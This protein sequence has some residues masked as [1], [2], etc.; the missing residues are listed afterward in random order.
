M[1]TSNTQPRVLRHNLDA[2]ASIL[3]GVL[4]QNDVL[5]ELDRLE[6]DAFYDLRHRVV[7]AAMRNLQ[8]REKP[9]DPVTLVTE[10]E[11]NGKLEAIG[12][13]AFLGELALKVPTPTNVV[14][15]AETV[16][17][18]YATRRLALVCSDVLER[19]YDP[20]CEPEELLERAQAEVS[21]LATAQSK[22]DTLTP[23][24]VLARRRLKELDELAA[25]RAAGET[26]ALTGLP[27][28][29]RGLDQ[30]IGGWQFSV[31][32]MI[33]AR[34]A[35][36]KSSLALASADACTAAGYG[37][38]VF[39]L[40]DSWQ[41]YV[42]RCIARGSGVP[43]SAIRRGDLEAKR[44]GESP[45]GAVSHAVM[46]LMAR[47]NWHVDDRKD[48]SASEII[49]AVRKHKP[50]IGTRLVVVDYVQLV[51]RNHRLDENHAL[52]EIITAF[53]AAVEPDE[54]WLVLSQLNR[55]LEE[56][57]DKRP[58]MPDLRGSG[59]L[60]ERPKVIVG[61]YRG[62]EYG[63]EPRREIDYVCPRDCTTP[64][65][66]STCFVHKPT[67]EDWERQAQV[68]VLKHSNGD[69]GRVWATWNGPTTEIS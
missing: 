5:L 20:D 41:T 43:A 50:R 60:E 38:H 68:L 42:D 7:F 11:R 31:V 53:A 4:L 23:I 25:R 26:D 37:A 59:A 2:E 16:E 52:D 32:N 1:P 51:R 6:V 27:T 36:G 58:T 8:A 22:P 54:V 64:A 57:V 46:R 18:L 63:G 33:A 65:N 61:L 19:C 24:G 3:G 40:E 44:E 17:K 35:M 14:H 34:P 29:V 67:T 62:S 49:R 28:G 48:L 55:K 39:S 66:A 30:R 13:I 47:S 9:I 10:I 15:Y 45:M 56:R 21:R 12:G 69:K